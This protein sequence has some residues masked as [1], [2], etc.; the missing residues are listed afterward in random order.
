MSRALTWTYTIF[1]SSHS[2]FPDQSQWCG[3]TGSCGSYD[4]K[5]HFRKN[6]HGNLKR[7]ELLLLSP[8]GTWHT[9]A[10]SV[11]SWVGGDSVPVILPLWG[12]S[13][14]CLEFPGFN[15]YW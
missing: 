7:Q 6:H 13:V 11:R 12:P 5:I 10:H 9:Q 8:K 2:H 4:C 3:W 1:G 15:I 14:G